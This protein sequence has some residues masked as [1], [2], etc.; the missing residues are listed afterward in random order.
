MQDE[1]TEVDVD[2]DESD[3]N[4]EDEQKM[5][6]RTT[7][8]DSPSVCR[9]IGLTAVS[10]RLEKVRKTRE[11][12]S[13]KRQR[14]KVTKV[15]EVEEIFE[16]TQV[17]EAHH[18]QTRLKGG[19]IQRL[20]KRFLQTNCRELLVSFCADNGIDTNILGNKTTEMEVQMRIAR[21]EQ[22]EVA[23]N[24]KAKRNLN[25][26]LQRTAKKKSTSSTSKKNRKVR[27]KKQLYHH[28]K[29][30]LMPVLLLRVRGHPHA[31]GPLTHVLLARVRGKNHRNK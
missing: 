23:S 10:P 14:D 18:F 2:G 31:K 24:R 17:G 20:S 26:S 16:H 21:R 12:D 19:K 9:L 11:S 1:I 7:A 4:N 13:T 5:P 22:D 6:A 25:A 29:G 30:P 28:A 27:K 8:R 3:E 15:I